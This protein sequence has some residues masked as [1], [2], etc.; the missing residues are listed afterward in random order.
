MT[1][2]LV[3]KRNNIR[4]NSL[5]FETKREVVSLVSRRSV[6]LGIVLMAH[7]S[8][9][10]RSPLV[11]FQTLK[12]LTSTSTFRSQKAIRTEKMIGIVI[13][14]HIII[15]LQSLP[16]EVPS[17]PRGRKNVMSRSSKFMRRTLNKRSLR[18]YVIHP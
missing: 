12:A 18:S 6:T 9:K 17:G 3:S 2:N 1:Q 8:K 10:F 16:R 15:K 4:L 7:L 5:I 14:I 11:P 13:S